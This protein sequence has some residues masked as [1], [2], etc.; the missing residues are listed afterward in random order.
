VVLG[1]GRDIGGRQGAWHVV[2]WLCRFGGHWHV[3]HVW[4]FCGTSLIL[5][6]GE[7]TREVAV[8]STSVGFPWVIMW[9]GAKLGGCALTLAVA[10]SCVSSLILW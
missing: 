6:G 9:S 10:W 3:R 2:I 1:G 7:G 8:G 5:P 4:D